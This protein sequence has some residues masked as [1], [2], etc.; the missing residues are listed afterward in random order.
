MERA[1]A[2]EIAERL[3]ARLV[4]REELSNDQAGRVVKAYLEA[5]GWSPAGPVNTFVSPSGRCRLRIKTR[6][7]ALLERSDGDWVVKPSIRGREVHLNRVGEVILRGVRAALAEPAGA[8][9]ARPAV[10][11]VTEPPRKVRRKAVPPRRPGKVAQR[12]RRN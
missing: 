7:V 9:L 5:S 8:P 4:E 10:A 3:E 11:A 1:L 2:S 6:V 12:R